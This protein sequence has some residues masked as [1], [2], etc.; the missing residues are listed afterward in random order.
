MSAIA[1][2]IDWSGRPAGAAVRRALQ[3]LAQQGRD[4]EGIWADGP[5]GLGW[6]Q[7]ILHEE[8]HLDEQPRTGGNGIRLVFDGR[9]DNRLELASSLGMDA[10][11]RRQADS[12]YVLAAFEKWG[13]D[14]CE[15]LLGDFAFAAWDSQQ[16]RLVLGRDAT[17]FRPLFFHRTADF[18]MFAT[19]PSALF[20]NSLVPMELDHERVALELAAVPK[21]PWETLYRGIERVQPG[22]AIAFSPGATTIL[23][24]WRPEE[25][26]ELRYRR[27]GDYVDAF[28]EILNQAVSCRLRTIHPVGSHLSSGWDSSTI[29]AVAAS[30]LAEA[31]QTLTAFTA[32]P[33]QGWQPPGQTTTVTDEG[34]VASLVAGRFPNMRHVLVE[35]LSVL[36]LNVIDRHHEAFECTKNT[37]SLFGWYERL[38]QNAREQGI[39]V[40]LSGGYGNRTMSCTGLESLSGLFL[41][42][43]MLSL[44]R[45]WIQLRKTGQPLQR[46]A[47]RTFGPYLPEAAW[48]AIRAMNGRGDPLR[49]M[50]LGIHHGALAPARLRE[51]ALERTITPANVHRTDHRVFRRWCTGTYDYGTVWGG[52]L[53]AFDLDHR[54]PSADRRLLVFRAGIPDGQFLR[55]GQ[56][57]WLLRRAMEGMLP[58]ELMSQSG[59][60]LQA[61]EWFDAARKAAREIA[62]EVEL[63]GADPLLAGLYDIEYLRRLM[64]VWPSTPK[65][66][67]EAQHYRRLITTISSARFT[68]RF[69]SASARRR[70]GSGQDS[71]SA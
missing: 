46:L 26:P 44:A 27:D 66:G 16:R 37:V 1:G 47:A 48:K 55:N 33:P 15:R 18:V 60:A 32:V 9:I 25:V 2:L 14:C 56:T 69:L 5:A 39:R 10:E 62:E 11:S 51:L 7:T 49:Q 50:P 59:R 54:D 31:N 67:Q 34:P 6:R 57:R 12:A 52:Y 61:A 65:N 22:H 43:R 70:T 53:A 24:H 63:M 41:G 36:D 68:R 35:G 8:D 64:M 40:M 71:N 13:M 3:A 58:Q 45:E 21:A 38:H 17:G 28:R 19:T 29:A 30:R 23:R 20:T 42:G 4:G